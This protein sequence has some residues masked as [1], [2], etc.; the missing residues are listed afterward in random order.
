MK[1]RDGFVE[2]KYRLRIE[3][4]EN[5]IKYISKIDGNK[6]A[7]KNEMQCAYIDYLVEKLSKMINISRKDI[8]KKYMPKTYKKVMS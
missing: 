4:Q 2:F 6:Y 1:I 8:Y 3:N 5:I 7:N